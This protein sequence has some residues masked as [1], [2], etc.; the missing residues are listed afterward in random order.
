MKD[1]LEQWAPKSKESMPT[2]YQSMMATN[3]DNG[4]AQG[5]SW[6]ANKHFCAHFLDCELLRELQ[7]RNTD[8]IVNMRSTTTA[9]HILHIVGYLCFMLYSLYVL[10][11]A[12]YLW[13]LCNFSWII[14]Y[15]TSSSC[16]VC[17]QTE[18]LSF[19]GT[20][21]NQF[22]YIFPFNWIIKLLIISLLNWM[23]AMGNKIAIVNLIIPQIV[24]NQ[25]SPG[26]LTTFS[27]SD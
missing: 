3:Q 22:H 27:Y 11:L 1:A 13:K 15:E 5:L 18:N 9:L 8:G 21:R 20:E 6:S 2:G 17:I 10:C 24:G 4:P 26:S 14:Y 12:I 23:I 7:T 16:W 25:N 19:N